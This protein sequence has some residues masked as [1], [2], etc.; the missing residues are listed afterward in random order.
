MQ[1]MTAPKSEKIPWID[2]GWYLAIEFEL[3][4]S[5]RFEEAVD[6]AKENEHFVELVDERG[7]TW[8]RTIFFKKN[9]PEFTVLYDI[10]K[11][12]KNT[13]FYLKG[14][15][16]K[17]ED[18]AIWY[19]CYARYWGH[20]KDLLDHDYCGPE[21][22]SAYPKFLGCYD[23]NIGLEWRD[24]VA[25]Y[26]GY[27]SKLWYS[28][29]KKEKNVYRIDKEAMLKFLNKA[30]KEYA[31]CPCYGHT[32]IDHYLLKLPDEINPIVHAEWQWKEEFLKIGS[33]R[34]FMSYDAF[35][36]AVPEICPVNQKVY[37]KF[38]QKIFKG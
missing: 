23:R 31:T 9:F 37:Q 2:R 12:W 24:P 32:L 29:G 16:I 1:K 35:L 19:E 22:F 34:G 28:F 7:I 26:Y 15:E 8:Y 25:N 11:G 36:N 18:F 33:N 27:R 38:M 10:V 3:S 14:D 13:R 6:L 17:K 5:M 30:N 4:K 20:R 21:K